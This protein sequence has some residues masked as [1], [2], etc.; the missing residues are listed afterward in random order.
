MS[1]YEGWGSAK[2]FGE[3]AP[4]MSSGAPMTP[5]Q[6]RAIF[7]ATAG[8]VVEYIDWLLY[9]SFAPVIA[10]NF[11]SSGSQVSSL[12][13]TF[14]VFAVGF[15]M[16]PIGGAFLGI[17][18]DR[19][20]RRKALTVSISMMAI[21]SVVIGFCPTYESMGIAATVILVLARLAQGFSAGGEYGSAITFMVESAPD[22][23]RG[24][25]G[26]WQWWAINAGILGSSVIAIATLSAGTALGFG[27]SGW[28]L[29]FV[30]A[31]V[32]GLVGLWI[33]LSVDETE[34]FNLSR[35]EAG[36]RQPIYE[37]IFKYP[38]ASLRVIGLAMVGNITGYLWIILYPSYLNST[39]G[40][41]LRDALTA[42]SIAVV[43]SLV[44][45]PLLGALSDRIGRRPI[46]IAFAFA[47]AL[48]AWPSLELVHPGISF[49][50]VLALECVALAIF[51]AY[52][53]TVAATMAEQFPTEIRVTGISLPYSISVTLF[54]GVTPWLVT[55][56]KNAG[57][58]HFVWIYVAIVSLIGGILYI[59]MAETNGKP[60]R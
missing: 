32:L 4:G 53:A 13:A 55:I 5:A 51:S 40:M 18:A 15:L 41:P 34:I 7:A 46:L 27:A 49:W 1:T 38:G 42:Q 48:F 21:A 31:G 23:R 33:R 16:R 36:R 43:L 10:A 25:A 9:A 39:T 60:I 11:F 2:P 50:Q 12:L 20:G 3:T 59:V 8:T 19:C 26:A 44:L 54:G 30:F 24:F 29:A 37:V 56:M 35:K 45:I 6:K 14:A 22:D 17:Y 52:C 47:S 28:R 58:G 57:Y